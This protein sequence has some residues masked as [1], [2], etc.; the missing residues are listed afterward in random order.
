MSALE[1]GLEAWLRYAPLPAENVKHHPRFSQIVA[2]SE[3]KA[4]PVYTAGKEIQDGLSKILHQKVDIT[5]TLPQAAQIPASAIVVGTVD[6]FPS[7]TPAIQKIKEEFSSL[8]EDGFW[9]GARKDGNDGPAHVLILGHNER[10]ALYGAF[11]FLMLLAQ[12]KPCPETYTS[13]PSA[14]IRWVNQWDNL[15]GTIERGYA[16]PSIFFKDSAVLDDLTR[17]AQYARLMASV[18]LN[19][20]IVN[21]VNSHCNL[22]NPTNLKGLGRIADAMRPWGV[23]IGVA[24]YF[25]TPIELGGL[26]T[27]DPLDSNVV[28]FWNDITTQLYKNVPD[29]LG[30]LIKANSE[31]QPGPLTYGRTLADGAN[32]FARALKPHGDGIVMYRAFVYNHHLD[33]SNWKNDRANAAVEFFDGLDDVFEDN[34]LV[35]IKYGPIDFQI[36]EPPSPLLAHLRRTQVIIEFQVAQ[37]YLGQQSHLVYLP[38]LWKTILDFDLRIDGQQSLVRDVVSGERFNWKRSGY[39]AVVNVGNDSTWLGSHLAMSNLYA[40]GRYCWDPTSDERA[41]I[42]DWT[43][44]TFSHHPTVVDTVTRL[45]MESWPTYENYSGNLGIQTLCDIVKTCH[46]GPSPAAMDGNGWGQWTRADAHAI[47]MDRTIATG[48]GYSGQYPSEVAKI[49]ENPETTPDELLLWFHHVQY[50]RRLKSGKTVIQHFYDAHYDGARNAQTFPVRWEALRGLIDDHRFEHTLFRL[51]YQAGHALVWRD[52]ICNF[53]L[54]KCGI[55]DEHHRVGSY[56]WRVKAQDMQLSGYKVVPITPFEAAFGGHAIIT[57]SN[58]APGIATWAVT[59]PVGVYNIAVNYYDH[60]GGTSQYQLFLGSEGS[61]EKRLIGNWAGSL[62][63][64]LLHDFSDLRDGHSA[65]RIYFRGV[66]VHE[67]DVLTIVGTPD[68]D[69]LAPVNYVSFLPVGIID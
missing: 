5:N 36:R 55:S 59:F 24:L 7:A 26:S 62:G 19:G 42:E 45:S 2:L 51:T 40:Y 66:Q 6:T 65:T 43:R 23:R 44:L 58:N 29:M 33:E 10:G 38:P 25:D 32:L 1:D 14:P 68:G 47:G 69:E 27:S 30:Y 28:T 22:L 3:A 57:E 39:A 48:T 12:D 60:L 16:G 15:N 11:H 56:K 20:I 13:S 63:K 21:N 67:G 35:Q 53:Y 37:E 34:V 8:K 50:T 17:V 31:G 4:S 54:A 41:V 52:S 46:Y 9:L 49:F 18:R 61:S 64:H